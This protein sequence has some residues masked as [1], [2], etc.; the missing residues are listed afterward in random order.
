VPASQLIEQLVQRGYVTRTQ[1]PAD[2]CAAE[3]VEQ[4]S[5]T[6]GPKGMHE[7]GALLRRVSAGGPLRPVW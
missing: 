7:L 3:A 4:W 6:L 1:D 2:A 5:S